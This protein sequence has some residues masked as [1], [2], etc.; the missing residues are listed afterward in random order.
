MFILAGVL[1]GLGLSALLGAPLR[2][3]TLNEAAASQRSSA[4][5]VLAL[6]GSIGQLVGA[7]VV[8]A[9][10]A[11]SGGTATGYGNAYLV[12]GA[13]TVFLWLAALGLKNRAAEK[14]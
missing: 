8:G 7:S 3:I 1:I 6:F 10:A 9:V 14:A 5:G 4:Q 13:V 11:S 12:T 2:Y